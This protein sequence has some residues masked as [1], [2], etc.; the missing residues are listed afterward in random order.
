MSTFIK[1][2]G[3]NPS[4]SR[5]RVDL[6]DSVLPDSGALYLYDAS[7]PGG[8]WGSGSASGMTIPNVA[9][10]SALRLTGSELEASFELSGSEI[11]AKRSSKKGLHLDPVQVALT[12]GNYAAFRLPAALA[13]YIWKNPGHSYYL[14]QWNRFTRLASGSGVPPFTSTIH[15]GSTAYLGSLYSNTTSTN[16]YPTNVN[17]ADKL[18]GQRKETLTPN[19]ATLT[20]VSTAGWVGTLPASAGTINALPLMLGAVGA[21]RSPMVQP[22]LVN[23]RS[24]FEDL[25]VSGRTYAQVDALDNARFTA[26][27]LTVGGRYYGDS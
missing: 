1:I 17:G 14:S 15:S 25:T 18:L 6:L 22:A 13:E 11:T 2:P 19:T 4:T 8:A 9:A 23:Y 3:I 7:H 5:P 27:C 16:T 21:V 24:Y 26:E 12:A 20:S 10:E